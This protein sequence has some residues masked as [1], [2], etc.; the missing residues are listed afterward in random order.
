MP[1]T[2][3]IVAVPEAEAAVGALRLQH[4]WSAQHGVPAH[5]T[6]LFPFAAPEAVD[7]DALR[8]LFAATPA[9]AYELTSVAHFGDELTYLAPS[10]AAAFAALTEAV[11]RRWPEH[12]PY[13][14]VHDTVIPHLT[15]AE[16]RLDLQ[17]DLPIRARADD[18]TLIEE[19]A[20]GRWTTR[21][22]FPLAR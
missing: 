2:A 14:G 11:W 22:R 7:E 5:I 3:L 1:R 19:Q 20:D 17:L 6:V 15:V 18:V 10:P 9:F 4:D 12:P 8:E 13:E 16:T 21:K